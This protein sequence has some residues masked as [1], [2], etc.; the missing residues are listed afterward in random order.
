MLDI[1]AMIKAHMIM[2]LT[3]MVIFCRARCFSIGLCKIVRREPDW[4]C[5]KIHKKMPAHDLPLDCWSVHLSQSLSIGRPDWFVGQS[6]VGHQPG[7]G[8]RG[9]LA[10]LITSVFVQLA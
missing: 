3:K 9:Q 2:K 5:R 4:L 1:S 7:A 8:R 6:G 10:K